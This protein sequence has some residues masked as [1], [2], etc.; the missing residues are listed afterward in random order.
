[1]KR[2]C[3]DSP[4]WQISVHPLDSSLQATLRT[5]H[6]PSGSLLAFKVS[7]NSIGVWLSG[8]F[9]YIVGVGPTI[10][11]GEVE[12][13]KVDDKVVFFGSIVSWQKSVGIAI[14]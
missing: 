12:A 8:W 5:Y 9:C 14:P 3:A 10:P 7:G 1:L 4:V 6:P 13:R 11:E 2:Y